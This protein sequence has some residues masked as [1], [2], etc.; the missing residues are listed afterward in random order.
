MGKMLE[1]IAHVSGRPASNEDTGD[2]DPS[3][4]ISVVIP[5]LN[6]SAYIRDALESLDEDSLG[7]IL[8]VDGG[9]EDNTVDLA[10]SYGAKVLITGRG[11]ARQMNAGAA[12]AQGEV[13]LFLHAD[14]RL[15]GGYANRIRRAL[16]CPG[17]VAGAFRLR[18]DRR[19]SPWL[20][21]IQS[22]GNWRAK[23]LQMPFGDQALFLPRALFLEVGGFAE[24]PIMEDVELI[25]RLR[26]RGGIKILP[27]FVVTSARRYEQSGALKRMLINK[28][29]MLGYCLGVPPERVARWYDWDGHWRAG[30]KRS[31][32]E[33]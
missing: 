7:E 26:S 23:Y 12:T 19:R 5:T 29:S 15:P 27:T 30:C 3:A 18:F 2:L 13:L 21:I 8:V 11:R 17:I 16:N 20:K 32:G 33:D 25:R 9:S 4:F 24:I 1:T 14:T 28:A 22:T 6:E 31:P 10:I